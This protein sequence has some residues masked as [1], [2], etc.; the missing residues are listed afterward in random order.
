MDKITPDWLGTGEF[1][2]TFSSGRTIKGFVK[3][4]DLASPLARELGAPPTAPNHGDVYLVA[5]AIVV[6]VNTGAPV[7]GIAPG[8]QVPRH[9]EAS[10]IATRQDAWHDY[11]HR[12]GTLNSPAVNHEPP[13]GLTAGNSMTDADGNT[14]HGGTGSPHGQPINAARGDFYCDL[15]STLRYRRRMGLL[16]LLAQT[17]AIELD[18]LLSAAA[19]LEQLPTA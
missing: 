4:L 2:W 15:N 8:R 5:Q 7:D 1:A 3:R 19:D 6:D 17:Q 12:W 9:V 11:W 16:E 13:S 18:T 14:W 10:V